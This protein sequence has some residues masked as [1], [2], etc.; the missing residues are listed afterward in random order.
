MTSACDREKLDLR[1]QPLFLKRPKCYDISAIGA[2]GRK[3]KAMKNICMIL[4]GTFLALLTGCGPAYHPWNGGSGYSES[5]IRPGEYEVSFVATNR[6]S[7]T[8]AR[9]F[10]TVRAA[11]VALQ[12][13]K[14]CFEILLAREGGIVSSQMIPE[15]TTVATTTTPRSRDG[16]RTS[17]STIN[18][19]GG[20]VATYTYP[21]ST[22]TI[23]LLDN[24]TPNALNARDTLRQA[25]QQG[26]PLSDPTNAL[27]LRGG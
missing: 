1:L 9:Y 20:Y 15:N 13:G 8:Q 14:P 22:L 19:T 11:E 4:A 21:I 23:R 24:P 12:M 2:S 17:F 3:G 10:A 16:S 27:L 25:M 5:P 7:P 26:I 18:T 6:E